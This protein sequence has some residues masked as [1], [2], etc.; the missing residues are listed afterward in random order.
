MFYY[1]TSL[2]KRNNLH[3]FV[4]YFRHQCRSSGREPFKNRPSQKIQEGKRE[5]TYAQQDPFYRRT[6]EDALKTRT[7]LTTPH[8]IDEHIHLQLY[9]FYIVLDNNI[10]IHYLI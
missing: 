8:Q 10:D 3:V 7:S 5:S 4:L 6:H 9:S 1:K 2:I